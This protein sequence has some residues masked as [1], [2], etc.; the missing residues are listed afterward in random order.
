M[1]DR[2]VL[3]TR[4]PG[5]VQE[6]RAKLDSLGVEVVTVDEFENVPEV[7]EDL[8]TLAGNAK[9]KALAVHLATGH[10]AL[11][12]DTGLE[13]YM[14]DMRPGVHSARFAGAD[15]DAAANRAKLLA[16]LQGQ[17]DRAARFRTILAYADEG[18]VRLFEGSVEGVIAEAE[19]GNEGFGYDALFQPEGQAHTFAEMDAEAKNA[20]SHR[21][22]AV[23]KFVRFLSV[24]RGA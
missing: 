21:A 6:L 1:S 9:K 12:D 16:D 20:I 24:Q 10:P 18:V 13:V 23:E 2:L 15:A 17:S 14:L 7:E 8:N 4:N 5:K 22:Q 19:R 11:A 3:A